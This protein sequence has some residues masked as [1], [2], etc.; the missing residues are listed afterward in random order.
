MVTNALS[1]A[2]KFGEFV[3]TVTHHNV[4]IAVVTET[5]FDATNMPADVTIPGY[6]TTR[7]DRNAFGGGVA[8]WTKSEFSVVHL[9]ELENG[10]HEI[11]CVSVALGHDRKMTLGA[12]YRPGTSAA[13]DLSLVEHLD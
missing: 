11:L 2:N 4:G 6:T 7:K 5:K 12:V 3:H 1:L 8:V 9:Q 10:I 13:N